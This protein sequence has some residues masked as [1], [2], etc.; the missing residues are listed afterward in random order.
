MNAT[1]TLYFLD[2]TKYVINI[3]DFFI[4]INPEI[5]MNVQTFYNMDLS[6]VELQQ[7]LSKKIKEIIIVNNEQEIEN[8]II[9]QD[10]S[11]WKTINAINITYNQGFNNLRLNFLIK[12]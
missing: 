9:Y 6:I 10:A 1:M 7:L 3:D 4:D 8:T 2:D 5:K 12:G 11:I